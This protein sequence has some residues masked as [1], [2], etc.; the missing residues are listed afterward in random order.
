MSWLPRACTLS[1]NPGALI[2]SMVASAAAQPM[3]LPF[4]DP[5]WLPTRHESSIDLRMPSAANGKPDA[6]PLAI[7]NMSGSTS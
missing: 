6:M 7:H 4:D 5:P 2:T 1:R 3:G